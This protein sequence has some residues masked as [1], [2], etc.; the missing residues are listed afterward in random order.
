MKSLVTGGAGFIGSN[1]VDKLVQLNHEV[2]VLD[3]L[4][5]GKLSNLKK[6][7]NKI[8]FFKID[9]LNAKKDINKYFKDVKWVFHMAG[10]ANMIQS[11]SNPMS[12]FDSNV[13][14][15]LNI[16]EASKKAKVKKFIYAASASCYGNP[17]KFPTKESCNINPQNPYAL[18]KYLGEH[19]VMSWAEI[20]N[21]PNISLRFFNIYGPKSTSNYGAVFSVFLNQKAIKK[22]LTVTGDGKQTR[23]FLHVLDLVNAMIE[24]AKN[25]K[26]GE[27]YN[28][29]S[30]LETSINLLAKLIGGPK[31]F[32]RKRKE[33]TYR[34]LANISKIK[35]HF[36]WRP[37]ISLKK[38]VESLLKDITN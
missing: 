5:T 10:K 23:D 37:K 26:N 19:L 31:V 15:T 3:N 6:I 35:N 2:I 9:I 21:M 14:G 38:G 17:K 32:V 7:K 12:Y 24:I 1:L 25:R 16:L 33:E 36:N 30:G 13:K 34:S 4:S 20:Y 8:K 11:E 18:T 27:I 29:G 28:L 22:P